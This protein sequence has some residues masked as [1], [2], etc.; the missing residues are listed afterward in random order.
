[1]TVTAVMPVLIE[2]RLIADIGGAYVA[3]L[4]E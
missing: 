2:R 4:G 3:I 1:M